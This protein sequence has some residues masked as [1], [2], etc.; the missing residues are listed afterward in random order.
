MY[1]R[2]ERKYIVFEMFE[3]RSC[4]LLCLPDDPKYL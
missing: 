3:L 2:M 1:E 4:E